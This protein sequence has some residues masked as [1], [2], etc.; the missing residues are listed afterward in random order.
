[1]ESQC[2]RGFRGTSGR[3]GVCESI[4]AAVGG[5]LFSNKIFP[6][7]RAES[8]GRGGEGGRTWRVRAEKYR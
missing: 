2:K 4:E 5:L 1:M 7:N 8:R 3:R 6:Q